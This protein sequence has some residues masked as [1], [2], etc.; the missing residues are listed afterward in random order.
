MEFSYRL[1]LYKVQFSEAMSNVE[2]TILQ[3]GANTINATTNKG[4]FLLLIPSNGSYIPRITFPLDSRRSRYD[5]IAIIRHWREETGSVLTFY[6][7]AN[8]GLCWQNKRK[9]GTQTPCF[10]RWSINSKN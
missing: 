3:I 10:I 5:K 6:T 8:A 2:R 7:S 4:Q 1:D 9:G